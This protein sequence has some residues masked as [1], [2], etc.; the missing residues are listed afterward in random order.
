MA[1]IMCHPGGPG[2]PV[3]PMYGP[4]ITSCSQQW[5]LALPNQSDYC[6]TVASSSAPVTNFINT[7]LLKLINNPLGCLTDQM[8]IP[9]VKMVWCFTLIKKVS[10]WFF[11][12]VHNKAAVCSHIN[13]FIFSLSFSLTVKKEMHHDSGCHSVYIHDLAFGLSWITHEIGTFDT[14]QWLPAYEFRFNLVYRRVTEY[15]GKNT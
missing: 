5:H 7:N 9:E 11:W 12:A 8:N 13:C 10:F 4:C 15:R 3:Q 2:L 1:R 14:Q 6:L